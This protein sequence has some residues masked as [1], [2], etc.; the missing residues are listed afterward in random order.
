MPREIDDR[1]KSEPDD[2]IA[3]VFVPAVAEPGRRSHRGRWL[4]LGA[5][6][7]LV[8]SGVGLLVAWP[9]VN[10]RKLDAV[11]RVADD[12]LRALM[13]DD[14][15]MIHRRSTIEEPPAIS[16][17]QSVRHDK[18]RTRTIRGSFAP[19]GKLHKKLETEYDYDAT[20]GR[21][22]PKNPLGPAAD[23]LDALHAAKDSAEKSGLYKKMASGDPN[24]IF[25]AAEAYG[26]VFTTLAATTLTPKKIVPTYKMLATDAKPPLSSEAQQLAQAVGADSKTWNALLK[27]PFHTLKADGPFIF[28]QTEVDAMVQDRLAS[29]GDPPTRMR[30]ELVRF[31]LEGIDTGWKVTATN[32]LLPGDAAAVGTSAEPR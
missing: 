21:F 10:P 9:R 28:E 13:T 27:R 18:S 32:R 8:V 1:A 11:E 25:D 24:D 7:V 14:Q 2:A 29:S 26:K 23:T 5:V 3:S 4:L 17:F 19:L 6:V 15:E 22:T 20:A 12:F 30:L 31:R 16:S